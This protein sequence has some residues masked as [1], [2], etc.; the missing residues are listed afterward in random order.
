MSIF[1][2]K[3]RRTTP[4]HENKGWPPGVPFIIGNEG[5]ERFSFYGMKSILYI[6]LASLYVLSGLVEQQAKNIAISEVH[7]FIAGVYAFPMIGAIISDRLLG[8]YRTII[9]LSLVYCAGHAYINPRNACWPCSDCYRIRR[10]KALC[11]CQCR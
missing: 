7:L 3:E 6:H 10:N 11:F 8:K 4:N 1:K 5:C 9:S 2:N